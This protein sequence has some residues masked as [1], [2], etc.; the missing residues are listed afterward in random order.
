MAFGEVRLAIA[1][2]EESEIR[3][4]ELECLQ[5]RRGCNVA[6][7]GHFYRCMKTYNSQQR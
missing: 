2:A 1:R 3:G 4:A 5:S 7:L 6:T